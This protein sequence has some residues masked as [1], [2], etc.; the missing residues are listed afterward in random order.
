[1]QSV[2]DEASLIFYGMDQ[3]QRCLS[4]FLQEKGKFT[5]YLHIFKKACHMPFVHDM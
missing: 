3:Y 2:K 4:K 5:L 1:M